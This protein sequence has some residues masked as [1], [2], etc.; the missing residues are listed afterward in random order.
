MRSVGN[1]FWPLMG[2]V[3]SI[4]L[5]A[6]ILAHWPVS[7]LWIIGLFVSVELIVNG[8]SYIFVSLASKRA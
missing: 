7:G 5:G 1:W 8:W 6:V 3:V 4:I 2:G